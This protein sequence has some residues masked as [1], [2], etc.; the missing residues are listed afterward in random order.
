[1]RMQIAA[2]LAG[3]AILMACS[4]PDTVSAMDDTVAAPASETVAVSETDSAAADLTTD[5]AT[6]T[7]TETVEAVETGT[8]TSPETDLACAQDYAPVCGTDGETYGNACEAEQAG[9]S[10][11][12]TGECHPEE[13]TE[14]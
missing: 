5:L 13:T 12:S 10:Q 11:A 3:G 14:H 6:D 2:A 9:V 4:A 8:E 1:M 7:V